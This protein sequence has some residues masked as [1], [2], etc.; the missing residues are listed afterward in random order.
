MTYYGDWN[1]LPQDIKCPECSTGDVHYR[2]VESSDGAYEDDEYMC[3][4]C[5][6]RWYVDG[7]DS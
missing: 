4:T 7:I 5:H 3:A 1:A 2:T 6:H